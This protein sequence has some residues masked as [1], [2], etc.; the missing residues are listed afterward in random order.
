[1]IANGL[2]G[3]APL[4]RIREFQR[5][6][7]NDS[8]KAQM[9]LISQGVTWSATVATGFTFLCASKLSATAASRLLTTSQRTGG[10]Q[11]LQPVFCII[12]KASIELCRSNRLRSD[13]GS[14][15]T[16]EDPQA[17]DIE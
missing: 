1:M 5:F 9:I 2:N 7:H 3:S 16:T 6:S 17:H 13:P 14:L 10:G 8:L 12:C 15:R 11:R 4:N